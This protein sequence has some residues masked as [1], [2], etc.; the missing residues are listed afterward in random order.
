MSS[1]SKID[2]NSFGNNKDTNFPMLYKQ[3]YKPSK[4][5]LAAGPDAGNSEVWKRSSGSFAQIC[6]A[7]GHLAPK[8]FPL[9]PYCR[10]SMMYGLGMKAGVGMNVLDDIIYRIQG[11]EADGVTATAVMLSRLLSLAI[12]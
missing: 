11:P 6:G 9:Q 1:G 10:Y 3:D 12:H 7:Y 8:Y 2:D 4:E 5:A